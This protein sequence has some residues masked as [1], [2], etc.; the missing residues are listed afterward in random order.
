MFS[1]ETDP[2][3]GVLQREE[4]AR[5]KILGEQERED[6]G[7]TEGQA[8]SAREVQGPAAEGGQTRQGLKSFWS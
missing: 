2:E 6:S 3:G 4:G 7:V 1:R 5:A 8:A